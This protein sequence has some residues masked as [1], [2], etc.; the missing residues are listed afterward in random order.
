LVGVLIDHLC[1]ELKIVT[2]RFIKPNPNVP[3]I[4]DGLPTAAIVAHRLTPIVDETF[5]MSGVA[6]PMRTSLRADGISVK[7]HS[8]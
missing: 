6:E 8:T 3:F 1:R 5:E 2:G 4:D 7:L